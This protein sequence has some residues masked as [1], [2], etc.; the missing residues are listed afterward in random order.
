MKR[1]TLIHPSSLTS[2]LLLLAV[3]TGHAATDSRVSVRY[4]K[5]ETFT[6]ASDRA[7]GGRGASKSVMSDL[8]R[9]LQQLGESQLRSDETLEIVFTDIDLAGRF[10]FMPGNTTG[11]LRIVRDSTWP[12][13]DFRYALSRNGTPVMSGKESLRDMNFLNSGVAIP[14]SETLRYEKDLLRRWLTQRFARPEP[15]DADSAAD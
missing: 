6:D 10:E 1:S 7:P 9:Y 11:D 12:S 2:L 8:E 15:D 13:L 5:P 3:S 4:E 14:S